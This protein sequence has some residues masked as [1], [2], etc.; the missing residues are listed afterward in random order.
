M[1][2]SNSRGLPDEK[3]LN[4]SFPGVAKR[5]VFSKLLLANHT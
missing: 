5:W 1:V 4:R 3:I 2:L